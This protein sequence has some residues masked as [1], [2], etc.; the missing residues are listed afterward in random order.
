MKKTMAKTP[1]I[2]L[3]L[4]CTGMLWAQGSAR[5]LDYCVLPNGEVLITDGGRGVADIHPYIFTGHYGGAYWDNNFVFKAAE[6]GKQNGDFN[7]VATIKD[8]KV[9]MRYD[10]KSL[11]NGLHIH[12]QLVPRD[13]VN[14]S[15][16]D[17]YAL[18]PY[19]DW[20]NAPFEFNDNEGDI[21]DGPTPVP[22][23]RS[24]L[25]READSAPISIGPSPRLGGLAFQMTAEGLHLQLSDNRYYDGNLAV[26]YSNRESGADWT[27]G[28]GEKKDF[29]FTL[30]FNRPMAPQPCMSSTPVPTGPIPPTVTPTATDTPYPPDCLDPLID[31]FEDPTRNGPP[32]SRSNR[33]GGRWGIQSS[34]GSHANLAYLPAMG[35]ETA[36]V[37][38]SGN[39]S[40]PEGSFCFQTPF[41]A[42]G[43]AFN[44]KVHGVR[45]IQFWMKGDGHSYWFNLFSADHPGDPYCVNVVPPAGRWTHFRI[46]FGQ[47]ARKSWW[48]PEVGPFSHPD[49]T[50]LTGVGFES[51]GGGSFAFGLGRVALYRWA[52][53]NCPTPVLPLEPTLAFT[54]TPSPI[55]TETP[56]P[57]PTTTFT[58]F[59]TAVWTPTPQGVRTDTPSPAPTVR[60][61]AASGAKPPLT[62][63]PRMIRFL[64][65]ATVTPTRRILWRPTPTWTWSPAASQAA[66]SPENR[67][68]STW[69]P[70]FPPKPD[71]GQTF[72]FFEP[73]A[74][75]YVTFADGSGHYRVEVLDNK[76]AVLEVI[77]DQKV[78]GKKDS[79]LEWDGLD[80]KGHLV[81]PGRYSIVIFKD[82]RVLKSLVVVR[83]GRKK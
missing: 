63:T 14:V 64:K 59:P 5:S 7:A 15:L 26:I 8:T 68:I 3:L 75:I 21:P 74:N 29:D 11:S 43:A 51:R 73:P 38:V 81:P 30:T 54:P 76:G 37:S 18:F 44:A 40:R 28:D 16:V 2:F 13:A 46:P 4:F 36:C 72:I 58:P 32:P 47:M 49:G 33:W 10:V 12:Y 9:D 69:A 71:Q 34:S 66:I 79:W 82:G 20:V 41:F 57:T 67:V 70:A 80:G 45:G 42:N 23:S 55:P 35:G 17:I 78:I 60:V 22:G 52:E 31:D 56:I 24:W 27:W 53:P 61:T 39:V 83:V 19:S 77:Y 65:A 50:G 1:W 62:S 6:S 48:G 25:L